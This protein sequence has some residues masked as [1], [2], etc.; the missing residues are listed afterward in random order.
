MR[1]GSAA[2]VPITANAADTTAERSTNPFGLLSEAGVELAGSG[3]M[4]PAIELDEREDEDGVYIS[5]EASAEV[6]AK[7]SFPMF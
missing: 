3:I 5:S 4:V 6:Q 1:N 7:V 2:A